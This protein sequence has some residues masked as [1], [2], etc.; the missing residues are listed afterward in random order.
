MRFRMTTKQLPRYIKVNGHVY[1]LAAE[2]AVDPKAKLEQ[3]KQKL[4]QQQQ[5]KQDATTQS[6]DKV[7]ITLASQ[8]VKAYTETLQEW[9]KGFNMPP[10]TKGDANSALHA[11]VAF[12]DAFLEKSQEITNTA[13][14]K[15][16][17][18]LRVPVNANT[19]KR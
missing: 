10:P 4:Q 15:M 18:M 13:L 19:R 3:T 7:R 12:K 11:Y 16:A 14:T 5:E 6:L 2:P 17:Q 1:K 9:V 8:F